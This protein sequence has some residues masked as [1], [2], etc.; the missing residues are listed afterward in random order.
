VST[1]TPDTDRGC[2]TPDHATSAPS[3][4]GPGRIPAK[5]MNPERPRCALEWGRYG[6]KNAA[7]FREGQ[8]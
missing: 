3:R 8:R 4:A 7:Y 1:L 5:V 6:A 2:A